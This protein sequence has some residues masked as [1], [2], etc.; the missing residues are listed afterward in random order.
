MG[1]KDAV[2]NII[3]GVY[4]TVP[5]ILK[6]AIKHSKIRQIS[7][8]TAESISLPIFNQLTDEELEVL[9]GV[10]TQGGDDEKPAKIPGDDFEEEDDEDDE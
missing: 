6:E 2:K 8:K 3:H 10:A 9:T 5:H 4:N 7:I 1:T